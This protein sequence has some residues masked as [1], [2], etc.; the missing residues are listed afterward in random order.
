MTWMTDE[1]GVIPPMDKLTPGPG[2]AEKELALNA[3]IARRRLLWLSALTGAAIFGRAPQIAA[4]GMSQIDSNKTIADKIQNAIDLGWDDFLKQCV[5]V[6]E[7]LHRDSSKSG[8]EAYLYWLASM[9]ARLRLKEAPRAKLGRFGTLDPP[10]HFGR[11]FRGNPFFIVEWWLEPGAFLPPHCHPNAS[12]CTL[13]LEGEARI[14]NFE[15]VGDAP[16]FSSKQSFQV[17]ETHNEI[18]APGRLNTLSA[19]RDNIHTFQAGK[20]GARG[21]DIST[22]HGPDVG[23]SFLDIGDR[24]RD[25]ERRIYEAAW[26]KL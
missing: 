9:S 12:V 22:Y 26:K 19:F 15:I 8:Q 18:I 25:A 23:F 4:R 21:L 1:A 5:P 14:R 2:R 3:K 16:E 20:Q 24:A 17:R 6:A 7:E 10:V 13:G 11:S